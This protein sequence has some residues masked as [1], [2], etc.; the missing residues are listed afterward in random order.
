MLSK[1]EM[2][3]LLCQMVEDKIKSQ[4]EEYLGVD[5]LWRQK[6]NHSIVFLKKAKRKHHSPKSS[7]ICWWDGTSLRK[8]SSGSYLLQARTEEMVNKQHPKGKTDRREAQVIT[9][10]YQK[11]ARKNEKDAEGCFFS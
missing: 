6:N 4:K 3:E 10:R 11:K 1:I 7:G 2:P 5:I 9:L 8:K